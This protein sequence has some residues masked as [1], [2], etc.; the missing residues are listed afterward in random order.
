MA[1]ANDLEIELTVRP[2]ADWP[3]V[4]GTWRELAARAPDVSFFLT[5]DWAD[6][7]MRAFAGTLKPDILLFRCGPEVVGA[8]LLVRRTVWAGPIPLTRVYLNMSGEDD[9]EDT[10]I[11]FNDVLCLGGW[12][13]AVAA[14]LAAH[15]A[16]LRWDEFSARGLAGDAEAAMRQWPCFASATASRI[17]RSSHYVDLAAARQG[18][19]AFDEAIGPRSRKNV[20]RYINLY[21]T[22]GE[23]RTEAA[24]DA[25]RALVM[26][27]ELI[28]LH[29]PTWARRGRPGAFASPRIV[30]LHRGLIRRAFASGLIQVLRVTAGDAVVGIA[31]NFVFRGKV[32]AYQQ[33]LRYE[34]D[35]RLHPGFVTTA[36]AVQYLHGSR[37]RRIRSPGR[38][39]H[40]QEGDLDRQPAACLGIVAPAQPGHAGSRRAQAG[41]GRRL[42]PRAAAGRRCRG[43]RLTCG[44]ARGHGSC[45]PPPGRACCA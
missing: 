40:R 33:G 18:S 7:W 37:A 43:G 32:Y 35:R 13:E 25:G 36:G 26:L 27:D 8:C 16:T 17:E 23:V 31:Y 29:Q 41:A 12:R 11:E 44:L 10:T 30:E 28:A 39:S 4:S 6:A 5:A 22:S 15:L 42:R 21:R 38:P 2:A 20:R 14:R 45:T 9:E 24:A 34:E 19:P 3:A 1:E